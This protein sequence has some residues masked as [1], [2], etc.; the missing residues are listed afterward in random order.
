MPFSLKHFFISVAISTQVAS[1]PLRSQLQILGSIGRLCKTSLLDDIFSLGFQSS[2][3]IKHVNY[4]IKWNVSTPTGLYVFLISLFSILYT[5]YYAFFNLLFLCQIF[6][7]FIF[8]WYF[9]F[10]FRFICS[11]I[12]CLLD[13][14]KQLTK[15]YYKTISK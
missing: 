11:A 13:T 3:I 9:Y 1:A 8:I 15:K 2:G 14:Y 12:V 4:K 10:F 7:F 6:A 5:F